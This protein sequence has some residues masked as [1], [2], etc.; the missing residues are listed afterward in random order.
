MFEPVWNREHI[1]YV[2]IDV[3][4]AISIEGR[5]EFYEKTGAFRDMVVTHLFQVLGFVAM[6]PPNALNA[7]AIRDEQDKVFDAMTPIDPANVVRGQYAGYRAAPGVDPNSDTETFVALRAEVDNWRWAG[8]PF[9]LRSG[10]CLAE[11]RQA[12]TFGF[13]EPTMRMFPLGAGERHAMG[14]ELVIDFDDPG[15]ISLSFLAKEPGPAMRLGSAQ[16]TFRYADSFRSFHGLE[17]YEHLLLDAMKGDQS[18]FTRADGIERL[19]EISTPLLEN[20]PP[21]QSYEPGSWGPGAIEDL[22]APFQWYLPDR[23]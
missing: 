1:S 17:G 3:P 22:V 6:E 21:V 8:V 14:N 2:Q 13:K 18:L 11:R 19:W 5:T 7:K 9:Y 16:M 20:P 4:E 12:I 10:K 23:R 15:W